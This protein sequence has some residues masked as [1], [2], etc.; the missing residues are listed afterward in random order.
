MR[1]NS[2]IMNSLMIRWYIHT[3]RMYVY[4]RI[5]MSAIYNNHVCMEKLHTNEHK[6][7]MYILYVDKVQ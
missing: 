1:I 6:I 2:T 7:D 4:T 5:E 3:L